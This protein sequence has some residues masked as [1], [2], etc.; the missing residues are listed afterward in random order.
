[1]L[2]RRLVLG[3]ALLALVGCTSSKLGDPAAQ[4]AEIDSDA[5]AA[6][7]RLMAEDPAAK[8]FAARAKGVAIFR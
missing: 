8:D 6:L 1:M 5:D 3:T 7:N 2:T 4:R